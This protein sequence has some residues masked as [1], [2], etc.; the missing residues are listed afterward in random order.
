[1]NP[2]ATTN[3]PHFGTKAGDVF[4]TR[5]AWDNDTDRVLGFPEEMCLT[6]GMVYPATEPV[7]CEGFSP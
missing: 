4:T 7:V 2:T 6:F 5:C 1:M 3:Q